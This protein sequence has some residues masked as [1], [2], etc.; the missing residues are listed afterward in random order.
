[1]LAR[2]GVHRELR[3]TTYEAS[4]EHKRQCAIELYWLQLGLT[5][6]I[7]GFGVGTV[8]AHAVVQTGS[9]G[10]ETFGLGVVFS[11][12]EAHELIHEV[13][14]EPRR[15]EG[16]L[17]DDPAGRKDREVHIGRPMNLAGRSEDGVDRRVRV[18]EADGVDAVEAGKVI[19]VGSVVAVPG[20]DVERGMVEV[21][22]PKVSLKLGDDLEG[23]VVTV[24]VG[25]MRGQEVAAVGEAVCSNRAEG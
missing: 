12:D 24:I 2:R 9:A 7:E 4:L 23:G 20:D 11:F 18:V 25:S 3:G 5:G 10:D 22:S 16:V 6:A 13:A 17:G 8:A 19:L 15:P 21:R 14:V 1:M